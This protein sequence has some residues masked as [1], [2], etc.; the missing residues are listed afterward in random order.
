[1]NKKHNKQQSLID[2][3]KLETVRLFQDKNNSFNL[4]KINNTLNYIDHY[5][6]VG[7]TMN[8]FKVKPEYS[9][10]NE[11][12]VINQLKKAEE[13]FVPEYKRMTGTKINNVNKFFVFEYEGQLVR[14][15]IA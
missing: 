13:L 9:R 2:R 4:G 1:M 8:L 14:K 7:D 3:L 5:G 12:T 10:Q 15:E 6:V 11:L